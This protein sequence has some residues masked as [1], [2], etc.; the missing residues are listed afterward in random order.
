ML[1]KFKMDAA[2]WVIPSQVAPLETL[3]WTK[4]AALL[5]R[6]MPLRAMFWFRL[7]GWFKEKKIPFLPGAVQRFIYRWHGLEI[8]VGAP[9]GGGLYVPHPIGT[10]IAPTAIGRNCSIIAA[11]TIGMR[12]EFAFP[13]LGDEVFIGAGARVLGGIHI[14]DGAIIGA[15]AVVID[16]VPAGATTVGIPAR[17]IAA[18]KESINH[19]TP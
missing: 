10:V 11:V 4:I 9:V 2:R 13:V 19:E 8:A 16:D 7:G 6:H 3:S 14:G 18:R 17:I 5:L 1:T 12:S 15:N